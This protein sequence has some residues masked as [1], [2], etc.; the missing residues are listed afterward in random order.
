[1]KYDT[2]KQSSPDFAGSPMLAP[3]TEYPGYA[4]HLDGRTWMWNIELFETL[5]FHLVFPELNIKALISSLYCKNN[6][7]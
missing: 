7:T 2:L 5:L 3:A 4:N 6:S 1:M